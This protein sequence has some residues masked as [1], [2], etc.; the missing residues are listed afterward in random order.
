MV[1]LR[2]WIFFKWWYDVFGDFDSLPGDYNQLDVFTSGKLIESEKPV[3]H[4][5]HSHYRDACFWDASAI[6]AMAFY[7]ILFTIH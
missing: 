6:I 2:G 7:N 4:F 5:L 3:Y 1:Q